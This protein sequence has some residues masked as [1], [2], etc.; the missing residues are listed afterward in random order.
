M[1]IRRARVEDVKQIY[2]IVRANPREV[3]P[4]SFP[5]I[6]T[7]IDRFYV[8]FDPEQPSVLRGVCS[9]KV[10]PEQ[11]S[12]DDPEL[13]IE[14]ISLSVRPDHQRHGIGSALVQHMLRKLRALDPDRIICLT[15]SPPFFEKLGFREIPKAAIL[16]KIYTGCINCTRYPGPTNCPEVAMEYVWKRKRGKRVKL[17]VAS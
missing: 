17:P 15:F 14:V 12:I 11:T 2:E 9:W 7:Q 16:S 8:E 10:L 6:L 4:R 13:W 5:D 3:I 1:S